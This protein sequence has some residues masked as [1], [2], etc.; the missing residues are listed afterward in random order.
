MIRIVRAQLPLLLLLFLKKTTTSESTVRTVGETRMCQTVRTVGE[1]MMFVEVV[2]TIQWS[3]AQ[4]SLMVTWI[5]VFLWW[6]FVFSLMNAWILVE[7]IS[8]VA[9]YCCQQNN[10]WVYVGNQSE[11]PDYIQ[12]MWAIKVR[13]QVIFRKWSFL[14]RRQGSDAYR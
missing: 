2:G 3:F 5:P 9:R 7:S 4:S 6:R 14:G 11:V 10:W 13:C 12:C 1:M 8:Y